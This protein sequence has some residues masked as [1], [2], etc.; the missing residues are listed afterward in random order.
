MVAKKAAPKSADKIEAATLDLNNISENFRKYSETNLAQAQESFSKMQSVSENA[1]KAMETAL[2]TAKVEGADLGMKA[3][4]VVQ[5]NMKTSLSHVEKLMAVKSM[6]DVIELQSTYLRE[7][8]EAVTAQIKTFQEA[9][10]KIASD[11][12]A[13]VQ[14]A[15][16]Q[17]MSAFKQK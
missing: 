11:V 5:A 14:A 16:E 9:S 12:S 15:A 6:A 3:L 4:D 10:T 2:E 1:S 7:Q 17:S 13:P 8:T